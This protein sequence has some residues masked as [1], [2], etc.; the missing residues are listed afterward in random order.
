MYN[1]DQ[2]GEL[3]FQ[4]HLVLS[5][6]EHRWPTNGCTTL[7]AG[8]VDVA[9]PLRVDRL[10]VRGHLDAHAERRHHTPS[11][12]FRF[13]LAVT[14]DDL[15]AAA[16]F[17][18][19]VLGCRRGRESE[20]WIDWELFGHQVVTHLDPDGGRAP[21]RVTSD[22]DGRHVPVP[23]F[24]VLLDVPTFHEL[25]DRL[26]VRGVA[27]VIEPSL[28]LEGQA[29]QHWTMFVLDP[30]GNALEFKA[31]ADDGEVFAR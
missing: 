4:G 31:F 11:Q 8:V 16:E 26:R 25:S 28:R 24:G 20:H 19:L 7:D 1:F 22:V 3:R 23:H 13:H 30:A 6:L 15:A 10:P 2:Q 17:Y 12:R 14:V 5:G 27:F 29:G 9:G 21:V 18:G